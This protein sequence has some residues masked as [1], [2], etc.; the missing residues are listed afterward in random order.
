MARTP[1]FLA[2]LL[3]VTPVVLTASAAPGEQTPELKKLLSMKRQA[4]ADIAPASEEPSLALT[5]MQVPEP[6]KLGV[7]AA[8]PMLANPVAFTFDE[9]GRIFVAETYRY[10]TSVL[11]IRDFIGTMLEPDLALRTIEDR[12]ALVDRFFGP[13]GRKAL[14][15]E[16]ER[17]RL[18]EDRDGDGKADHSALYAEG[19]NT[20]LDG[21]GS[22]VLARDGKVW[23][24]NIPS[25]WV[26]EDESPSGLA[27]KR[28]ELSRG[29]GVHFNYTG[30]DLHGLIFGPDGKIYFSIGDRG[31]HL[32]TKEGKVIALPDTGAVFRCDPDGSNLEVFAFGLRNPQE[33]AFDEHGNLWT[34][35]NDSDQSDL[36][37]LVHILEGGDSGWTI[38]YQFAPLGNAGPWNFE[39]LWH[40]RFPEQAA[41]LVP[42]IANIE[43]GPSGIAYYPGTGLGDTY[44]GHLF[45]TH[46]KGS[47]A[48]S[49]IQTYTVS[50]DGATFKIRASETFLKNALPT[51]VD[52]GPDGRMY[53][54]DWADGW[55]K[56]RRGRIYTI[57]NPATLKDPIV[58]ETAR[59]LREGFRSREI[60]ELATLLGHAD[61]RVRQNAQFELARRKALAGLNTVVRDT[62]APQYARLH[63]IWGLGQIARQDAAALATLPALLTADAD[64][65][66]RA[67]SAK[68]LGDLK[69]AAAYDLLIAALKD[70][71][72]R[73]R[74]FAAQGLGK[75]GRPEAAGPL[76]ELLRDNADRDFAL[77][78]G[79]VMGL[80]G[81][82]NLAA[83]E[84]AAS[85]SSRSVRLGVL[86]AYRRLQREEVARFL[87]DADPLLAVEAARAINDVP[88]VTA[89]PALAAQLNPA[90]TNDS[91]TLRALNAHFRIGGDRN[92]EALARYAVDAQAPA[93]MRGEAI[94][95]L[96]NWGA[97]PDRDRIVG[98]YRPLGRRDDTI[99]MNALRPMLPSLLKDAPEAVQLATL[100]ALETLKVDGASDLYFDL[101]AAEN[102]PAAVRQ[103]A[104][105]LLDERKDAR[106]A[107][108]VKVAGTS[109][110]SS[111]RLAALPLAARLSPAEALPVVEAMVTRSD[112]AEQKAGYRSLA[113][114]RSPRAV[115]LLTASFDRLE[116]GQL[117]PAVQLELIN[118]IEERKDTA[119]ADRLARREAALA[120]ST[121]ALAPYRV[122]LA[123][124]DIRRGER[125]FRE[126]PVLA[127]IRCHKIGDEGGEAGPNL[128]LIGRERTAEHLL[129]SVVFPN[130]AI[131][132][133]FESV[134]VTLKDGS[135]EVGLVRED[136]AS[137]LVLTLGDGSV[138]TVAKADIAKRESPPSS[139]P[140]IYA[141]ILTKGE[142]RDLVT[143]LTTLKET[144]RPAGP[145]AS[146][147]A[148]VAVQA[149][150]SGHP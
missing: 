23:F 75:L 78:H 3:A 100:D 73:V 119:L 29:Y 65:E 96:A 147:T 27:Q 90:E 124:G 128:T 71:A 56:S 20:V 127:C 115:E 53:F 126:H 52:F 46:F 37:R 122:A 22:G 144:P 123:G 135:S 143:Y 38:G 26:L 70:A 88:I 99:A 116:A 120:A 34:G 21:I 76:L 102:Q 74:Y 95:H 69:S 14:S 113:R 109:S 35:D 89:F 1:Y 4:E 85:D 24:T 45:I 121:D 19:F 11:D 80:V 39:K 6:L 72:P 133:G 67:Q 145:R 107:E 132:P 8:E 43:D 101:V 98:V 92:A 97:P 148:T 142:L 63:A 91:I 86:L 12:V 82:N 31:T 9:R 83:L 117:D 28:T 94:I 7:W 44:K 42:G 87:T 32:T 129:E 141:S 146:A 60:A 103:A 112:I 77:R 51:D 149:P 2:A 150:S 84:K 30:H 136:N 16:S 111:L 54:S 104:L 13:E 17:I 106:L 66:V 64:A 49:G 134:V 5:G 68:V 62:T 10:R 137:Q 40:P 58:V 25:L 59:L 48:R 131:S 15:T 114:L 130:N 50:P 125:L 118:A 47:T 110:V 139:M 36:E 93:K 140:A 79:A 41:Y 55:P 108:A 33:L 61:Q 18:L 57:E 81:T 138:R 105:R